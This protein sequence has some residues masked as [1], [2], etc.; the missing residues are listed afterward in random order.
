MSEATPL[1]THRSRHRDGD[2]WGTE[3][4]GHSRR[5]LRLSSTDLDLLTLRLVLMVAEEGNLSRAAERSHIAASAASRRI[6]DF[7]HR[8]GV[9]L[10]ERRDRG[11]TLTPTGAQLVPELRS[12][13]GYLER[14]VHCIEA[15]H[16]GGHGHVRIHAHMSAVSGE[17]PSRIVR[18]MAE[19]QGIEVE[20]VEQTSLEVVHCV[21]Q[22]TADLGIVASGTPTGGLHVY[23]WQKDRLVVLLPAEHPL[24]NSERL[25]LLELIEEPFISMQQTSA[26]YTLCR[27]QARLLG[28]EL[29][30]C[31]FT[32]SFESIRNMVALG[33]GIAIV[34]EAAFAPTHAADIDS[35]PLHEDWAQRSLMLCT[36]APSHVSTAASLLVE[37]LI[38]TDTHLPSR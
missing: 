30:V 15:L 27:E 32:T 26:L 18:F 29:H 34:P 3:A 13:F 36:R 8:A 4:L 5:H 23:N 21:E 12:L 7:E 24:L 16:T 10:F 9:V 17:L 31:A 6:T 2:M 28:Q 35:R 1:P 22:G 37:H 19:H 33:L 14:M 11:M 38:G 25:S 20:L